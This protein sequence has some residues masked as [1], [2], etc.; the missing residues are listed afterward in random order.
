[1]AFNVIYDTYSLKLSVQSRVLR[2]RPD[3]AKKDTCY[4][5]YVCRIQCMLYSRRKTYRLT[6]VVIFPKLM[7]QRY[8]PHVS[9]S[10]CFRL[11]AIFF[12]LGSRI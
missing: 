5:V 11:L 3:L 1:M 7:K 8:F 4:K 6:H 10:P 9:F 2:S 12:A